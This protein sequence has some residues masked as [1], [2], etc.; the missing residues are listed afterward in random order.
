MYQNMPTDCEHGVLLSE[1]CDRCARFSAELDAQPYA[2]A[3]LLTEGKAQLFS[4]HVKHT[5]RLV[6]EAVL[7]IAVLALFVYAFVVPPAYQ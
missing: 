2:H 3:T 1:Y 5:A 7:W 4:A 6:V